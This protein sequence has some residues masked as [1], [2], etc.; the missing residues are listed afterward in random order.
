MLE[1]PRPSGWLCWLCLRE[2][3]TLIW[4]APGNAK[5]APIC[6]GCAS[7]LS[8][9]QVYT[10][11]EFELIRGLKRGTRVR[12]PVPLAKKLEELGLAKV[13]G[14]GQGQDEGKKADPPA[15]EQGGQVQ[16]GQEQGGREGASGQVGEV[17]RIWVGDPFRC[18]VCKKPLH[19]R[20]RAHGFVCKN[21]KCVNYWKNG[22]GPVFRPAPLDRR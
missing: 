10:P 12:V 7:R 2:V 9:C 8:P 11:E 6:A 19:W 21:P 20:K 15:P 22:V 4:L 17:R 13:L 14:P 5:A 16:A 18:H 3:A 1:D